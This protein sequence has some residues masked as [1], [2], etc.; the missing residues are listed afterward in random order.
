MKCHAVGGTRVHP[1]NVFIYSRDIYSYQHLP[2]GC[3]FNLKG[4]WI[5]KKIGNMT[6]TLW[7]VQVHIHAYC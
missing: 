5:E 3:Q 4:C 1:T 7:K 6:G 2:K